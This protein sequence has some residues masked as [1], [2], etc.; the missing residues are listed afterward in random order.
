MVPENIHL[1]TFIENDSIPVNSTQ[2]A[3]GSAKLS[4]D[5]AIGREDDIREVIVDVELP[6]GPVIFGECY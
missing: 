1:Q 4:R 2:I 3:V 5:S 6:L